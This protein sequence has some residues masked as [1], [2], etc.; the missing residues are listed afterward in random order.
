MGQE[1]TSIPVLLPH[2]T[3]CMELLNFSRGV[4][5]LGEHR[6]GVLAALRARPLGRG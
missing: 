5:E 2:R 6:V 3:L 4:S 1:H